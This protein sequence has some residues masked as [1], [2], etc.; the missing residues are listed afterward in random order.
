[1]PK[2]AIS[3]RRSDS[4]AIVGRI[5]DR[6][7]DHYGSDE[8]F[9]DI[10]AIPYG[11][12][13]RDHIDSILKQCEV[14]IAVVGS[15]W[16][17]ASHR[18]VDEADPVR[19]EVQTALMQKVRIVPVLIDDAIMPAPDDLPE[20]LR[21]FS[22]LNALRIDTGL[23]FKVH[24]GRLIAALDQIVGQPELP[25]KE[26]DAQALQGARAPGSGGKDAVGHANWGLHI[27]FGYVIS[28]VIVMLLAH[29]LIVLKLDLNFNFLRLL[30][31]VIP[32]AAGFL[33][34]WREKRG[35][36]WAFLLGASMAALTVA[37][38]QIFM[39]LVAGTTFVPSTMVDWREAFEFLVSIQVATFAG[40]LIARIASASR[41]HTARQ[42][43]A[44]ES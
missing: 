44:A 17:G 10:D 2:I 29:Y 6:L 16:A 7:A 18:I 8:I 30:D 39:A 35:W 32:A 38:M 12:D 27:L 43:R 14:L 33:L 4:R 20:S 21:E 26:K 41:L 15:H 19:I 36:P 42:S 9:L 22:Y 37:G 40:N 34:F 23:D 25:T 1:M 28:P 5:F 13:F 31:I 11:R 24:I 3:Y